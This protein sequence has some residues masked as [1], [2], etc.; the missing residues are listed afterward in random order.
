MDIQMD[1]LLRRHLATALVL[2]FIVLL[3]ACSGGGGS[4]SGGSNNVTPT[5]PSLT[6]LQISPGASSLATG[7]SQQFTAS[8]KYSDG[9][10]KDLT[11]SAQWTS[12]DTTVVSL[13]QA[14][15]PL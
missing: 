2:S 14:R 7:G 10:S 15:Q 13:P 8:G 9:S 12:S 11:T 4:N 5:T 3:L 6:S 1:R